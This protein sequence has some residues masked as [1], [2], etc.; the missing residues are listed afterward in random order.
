MSWIGGKKSL[1]EL[2]VSLF[3]LYYERYIEVFGGGGWVLFHKP[4]GNDFEVYNDFN[5]LLTNLYRCVREKPN[6]LID[7][8]YFV[9]NSREDFDI[10]KKALAKDSPT[11]DVI[12]ASYFYQLIRYSY[13]SGL[14]SFGSQPHDMWSNFPIIEQAHRR[15][16][17][18]VVENKD[19][20]K[21]IRQYDRPVS[22]FYADPPY[23][24]TEKYYKNVGED[25]FKK[26]DHIRLRDTLMGI[27]GKFLLSYNDCSFIRELYDAPNI[28]IESYTRINNIKQ[29]YDNGAQF[30]EIL[31]ANYDMHER[32]IN[33]PSQINLFEMKNGLGK[34]EGIYNEND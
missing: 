7:A 32:E 4:P 23:F 29:R 20:E 22:F 33:S 17:K 2:I 19:F 1:R 28:Q 6:E 30:P 16:S 31:V 5:G 14:T 24:E 9:L 26:E 10:V 13:A 15:L 8:L 34:Q 21:L 12:R 3:P 25:G 27:E 18:V 11:S